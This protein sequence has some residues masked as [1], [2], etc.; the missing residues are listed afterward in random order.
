MSHYWT[1][2]S[3]GL[4]IPAFYEHLI[5]K[6]IKCLLT[7]KEN[8]L[9]ALELKVLFL[10]LYILLEGF[11]S[12]FVSNRLCLSRT[13]AII[14]LIEYSLSIVKLPEVFF[15]IYLNVGLIYSTVFFSSFHPYSCIAV[16]NWRKYYLTNTLDWATVLPQ[17]RLVKACQ[18]CSHPCQ[19][20]EQDCLFYPIIIRTYNFL[21][22]IDLIIMCVHINVCAHKTIHMNSYVYDIVD[23]CRNFM[24]IEFLYCLF[25]LFL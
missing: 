9:L 6:K 22:S 5:P 16:W 21:L 18:L 8:F 15:C 7:D 20:Y 12:N 23:T 2:R 4:D 19:E 13:W 1:F 14:F 11:A 25:S 24:S 10:F 17:G 3:T